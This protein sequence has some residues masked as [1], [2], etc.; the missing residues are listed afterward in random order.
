MARVLWVVA[1]AGSLVV[2][3]PSVALA[4][5]AP[6]QKCEAAKNKALPIGGGLWIPVLHPELRIAPTYTEWTYSGDMVRIPEFSAPALGTKPN[7]VTIDAVVP[8]NANGTNTPAVDARCRGLAAAQ[9]PNA[10][11]TCTQAHRS[12]RWAAATT[13]SKGSKAPLL[14][15]PA[16]AQ[17]IVGPVPRRS[18]VSHNVARAASG[19]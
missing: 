14:T 7:V 4:Q 16:C 12:S 10:P 1:V 18:S 6:T 19:S 17:T 2:T 5:L 15:Q 8:D 13:A 3:A 9:R 11:S